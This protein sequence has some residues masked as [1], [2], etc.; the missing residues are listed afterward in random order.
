MKKLLFI[1]GSLRNKGFNYQLSKE[2]CEILEGKYEISYLEYSNIPYMNQNLENA[3][4]EI[5]KSIRK[6]IMEN[7]LVL[8]FTPEYNY[9]YPGVLKNLLA[10]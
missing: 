4:L 3:E 5:M 10:W 8:I 9:S 7:D 2:V 1:I 6:Q